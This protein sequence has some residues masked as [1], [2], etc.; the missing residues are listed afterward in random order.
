MWHRVAPELARRFTVV[1]TDLRGYGESEKPAGDASH[2]TY[3]KRAMA[4]D[5]VEVMRSLGFERF[6]LVGHDRGA[7]VAHRLALDHTDRV[8]RLAVLDIVPTYELYS[9]VTRAFATAYFHWFLLIQ[10][11]PFPE[12]LLGRSAEFVLRAIC[13]AMRREAVAP[14]AFDEYLRHFSDPDTLHAMCEDYRAAA[15][16]DLEHDAADAGRKVECPL[17]ALWGRD[18]A[19]GHLYDVL[20]AWRP[21]GRDVAGEAIPG[22]HFLPEESPRETLD[23]LLRF[24]GDGG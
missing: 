19:M 20:G 2:E 23:A 17:L 14:E 12:T 11:A 8:T 7:R 13:A 16:I 18:G 10:P 15:S 21:R 1:A 4:Q 22:G 9:N 24:L 6:A 3:S 5:Q